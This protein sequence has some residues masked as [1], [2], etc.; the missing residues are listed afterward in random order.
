MMQSTFKIEV[1]LAQGSSLGTGFVLGKQSR[2]DP[3][4]AHYVLITAA[5][6]LDVPGGGPVAIL[7]AHVRSGDNWQRVATPLALKDG[8]KPRWMRHATADIAVIPVSLPETPDFPLLPVSL[9][10]SKDM[11]R[12]LGVH[13]GDFLNCLGFPLGV[14]GSPAGFAVLRL[15]AV[16]SYPVDDPSGFLLDLRVFGGNSGGPV[17]I[18]EGIRSM[19]AGVALGNFRAILGVV[20]QEINVK[21]VQKGLYSETTQTHSLGLAKVV[22]AYL[23]AELI[24]RL[25]ISE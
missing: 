17:Y 18:S 1:P 20:S 8:D 7:H 16:A 22:P 24:D 6:V 4:R 23:A 14:E 13:P 2:K 19:G 21:D 15:G 12:R 3:K 11:L 25:A 10:A 5:H 9:L